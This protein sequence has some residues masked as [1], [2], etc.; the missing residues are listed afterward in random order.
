MKT[1]RRPTQS[2]GGPKASRASG[3]T[4]DSVGRMG[5]LDRPTFLS[6][7]NFPVEYGIDTIRVF[8]AVNSKVWPGWHTQTKKGK[9]V[10]AY[11]K[12]PTSY[13][14]NGHP[15]SKANFE[16]LSCKWIPGSGYTVECSV[17]KFLGLPSVSLATADQLQT[18]LELI[19]EYLAD[20][21]ETSHLI[22]PIWTWTFPRTDIAIQFES[23]SSARLV[24]Y[25]LAL[26]GAGTRQLIPAHHG[27]AK[28][29]RKTYKLRL[30]DKLVE[31][32]KAI[33]AGRT[34]M[35]CEVEILGNG[36][37]RVEFPYQRNLEGIMDLLRHG[38]PKL[39]GLELEQLQRATA[40][41]TN[42]ESHEEI[43]DLCASPTERALVRD[44][45]VTFPAYSIKERL[46]Q[47][48]RNAIS[49]EVRRRLKAI[50]RIETREFS[51]LLALPAWPVA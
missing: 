26:A 23:T 36:L 10:A 46:K 6:K 21:A 48:P 37:R 8:I 29:S 22:P 7:I 20:V 41:L 5:L 11:R 30:Y 31:L 17:P 47:I 24:L 51:P 9:G 18:A 39:L 33:P 32:G 16:L 13:G 15:Y 2:T 4:S 44:L 19:A 34:L 42:E 45:L 49:P 3:A 25:W 27:S 12:N 28:V 40:L 1:V 35:R 14:K 43:L 38:I 50:S